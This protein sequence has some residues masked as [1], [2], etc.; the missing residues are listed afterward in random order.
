MDEVPK[1][2]RYDA[3][4]QEIIACLKS[5]AVVSQFPNCA[6]VFEIKNKKINVYNHHLQVCQ[7]KPAI[8]EDDQVINE[9]IDEILERHKRQKE[10][11]KKENKKFRCPYCTKTYASENLRHLLGCVKQNPDDREKLKAYFS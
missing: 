1:K 10:E 7:N 11:N 4:P 8:V 3:S 9:K 5:G 2:K 6:R